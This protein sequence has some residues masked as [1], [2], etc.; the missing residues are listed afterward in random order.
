MRPA[1][2]SLHLPL[3]ILLG[4]SVA[5]AQAPAGRAP[6]AEARVAPSAKPRLASWPAFESY[7][8]EA[9]ARHGVV[10]GSLMLVQGGEIVGETRAGLMDQAAG[11]PVERDTIFHW[12]SVTKTLTGIAILQ[13]RDAGRLSLDDPAVKHLPEL[14]QV[15]SPFGPIEEV[16]LRRLLSHTAG[17]RAG[18]WPW[19]GDQPW[20]PFE[21]ARYEQ[22]AAMLPYTELLFRP[23][24]RFS[25]SNP[26]I[27]FLGRIVEQ[28]TGEDYEV[29][30]DKNV[31]RPLG[32]RDSY[33]DRAPRY[34]RARRAHS[35]LR[36][37]SGLH[38]QPFDFDTGVTV[39]NGG[40]MAPLPDMARYLAFL[41]GSPRE[42]AADLVLK[43]SS[44]LEMWE[45]QIAITDGEAGQ[46]AVGLCFFV[47]RHAGRRLI[48]HSGDQAGFILHLYLDPEQGAGW[49]VA[50]NSDGGERAADRGGRTRALDH[51][52]RDRLLRDVWPTLP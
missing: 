3:T 39:S 43:R 12:A 21:P 51:E 42:A 4:A 8:R 30:L 6:A 9:V 19:G 13:L 18:T 14:R 36:D 26:G 49:V 17:F 23:G 27:V 11:R 16:T 15:R 1:T 7:F 28:L 5:S 35:Y 32:M 10:G 22:L 50:F 44:L 24:A 45:P 33:F 29:Y 47:E 52:V 46:E 25:Y 40:L 48:A 20:H 41:L 37:D 38:E 2:R 31:L 34:L